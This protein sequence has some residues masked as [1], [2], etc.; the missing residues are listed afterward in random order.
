[1]AGNHFVASIDIGTD[2]IALLAADIEDDNHLRIIAHNLCSS[3][4]VRKGSLFSIDSLARVVTK[5]IEETKKSFGIKIELVRI[6][7]SDTHLSCSDGKGKVSIS[8][9]VSLEDLDSVLESAMAMSTPTNK[10]KLHV[11]KK[12]FIINETIVVD[13]PLDMDAEVLESKVHIVTVSSSS[14]RNIENCLKQS[15]LEAEKIV[16]N[17][18]AKSNAILTQEERNSGVCLVDI[19]SGVTS[20]SVFHEEGIIRS[21]VIAFGGDEITQEIAY[22]FDTSFEEAQRLKENYGVAKS[23]ILNEEKFIAFTQNKEEHQLSS[24]ELSEVIED[25]Y[26]EIFTLLKNELNHHNL[27]S[28]IKSGFVLCGGGSEVNSIE[29][30][31]RDFFSRRVKIGKIQRSRISGLETVLTDYKFVGAIGLL[32]YEGDLS[33]SEFNES[34]SGRGVI[35]KIRNV[36]VGNF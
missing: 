24:L 13:N 23:S 33:K 2:K 9:T 18:I 27:N 16:L 7:I 30:L 10:E 5:L 17:P 19:G 12:K 34:N 35:D 36:I 14:V 15:G 26:R 20:Y 32:L 22:A 29:E 6:N 21:G 8:D 1:M 11:I 31:V 25:A 28:I 4:G 3:D